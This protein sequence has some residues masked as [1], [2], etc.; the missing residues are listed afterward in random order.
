MKKE[1]RIWGHYKVL[2]NDSYCKIKLL[3]IDIGKSISYQYHVHREEYWTL[4]QGCG[5]VILDETSFWIKTGD[6]MKINSNCSETKVK[7]KSSGISN[8]FSLEKTCH[9]RGV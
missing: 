2:Y 5:N 8:E 4:I 3:F 7:P 1:R 9:M 6:K